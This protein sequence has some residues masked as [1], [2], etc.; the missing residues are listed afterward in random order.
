VVL[1]ELELWPNLLRNVA[2]A[3]VPVIVMNG[4]ITEKGAAWHRW[5]RCVAP[6]VFS[7]RCVRLFCV[8]NDIYAERLRGLGVSEDRIRVTGMMKYDAMSVEIGSDVQGRVRKM[9]GLGS[10]DLVIVGASVYT[11]EAIVLAE[12]YQHVRGGCP[13]ARLILV[14]RHMEELSDI[15]RGIGRQG[16]KVVKRSTVS[17]DHPADL[18]DGVQ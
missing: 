8:Q 10:Q 3:N 4:R 1:I 17:E 12:I 9:L 2:K 6:W 11:D 13:D 7:E 15:L 14:P 18:G 16:L 5:L